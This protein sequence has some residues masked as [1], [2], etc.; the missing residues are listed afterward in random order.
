MQLIIKVLFVNKKIFKKITS[1]KKYEKH[2]RLLLKHF[3]TVLKMFQN[4][5]KS[6]LVV[7]TDILKYN[8]QKER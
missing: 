4:L 7:T 3:R 5:L 8:Y 6:H 1:I 2:I